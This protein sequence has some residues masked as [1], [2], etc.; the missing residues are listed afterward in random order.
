MEKKR[1]FI[2]SSLLV[3]EKNHGSW[4]CNLVTDGCYPNLK[5]TV[6]QIIEQ[7]KHLNISIINVTIT[8]IIELSEKD[9]L[10]WSREDDEDETT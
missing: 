9:Y 7:L 2:I 3:G 5:K 6:K 8:N 1:Y 10:D 4:S